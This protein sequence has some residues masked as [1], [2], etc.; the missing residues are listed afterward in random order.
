M[1]K[2]VL[3]LELS[4]VSLGYTQGQVR[5]DILNSVDLQIKPG[6]TVALLGPSGSGK[7]TLLNVAGLLERAEQG[8]VTINGNNTQ[9]LSE[10]E[11]TM[12]RR[13]DIGLI[14]QFHNLFPDF[15]AL[16][17]VM[18]PLRIQ[19]L[20]KKQATKQAKILLNQFNL[21]DRVEH[22]PSELSGGEQQRVAIARAFIHKPSI[23]LADE[24]TGSLDPSNGMKIFKHFVESAKQHHCATLVATH[25]IELAKLLDRQIILKNG[26]LISA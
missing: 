5:L 25:N 24:P 4:K 12:C 11:H 23:I 21:G 18:F 10:I 3:A 19:G 1:S 13:K 9:T 16:E 26:K 15:T 14:Y 22:L 2:V 8:V 20:S 7:S 17:N 6:E